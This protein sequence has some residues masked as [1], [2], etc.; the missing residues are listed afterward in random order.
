MPT[1]PVLLVNPANRIRLLDDWIAGSNAGTLNWTAQN[2]GTGGAP[3]IDDVAVD[4]SHAG[5]LRLNTGT[6]AAGRSGVSL[7]F[8]ASTYS[9][10]PSGGNGYQEWL[11]K[12]PTLSSAGD[13]YLLSLGFGDIFSAE[14]NN[15]AYFY[16]DESTSPNWLTKTALSSTRTMTDTGIAVLGNTWI[17]L[18]IEHNGGTNR[19]FY[20]N[21]TLVATHTTNLNSGNVYPAANMRKSAGTTSLF[22]YI[23]YWI[24]DHVFT[25]AR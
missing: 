21:G 23:D 1:A 24:M 13:R 17:K 7:S 19:L 25:T 22:T 9:L 16:Y 20:I 10:Q 8:N 4:A 12:I 18:R 2:A 5:I 6:T 11:I 14:F 15:G 3:V